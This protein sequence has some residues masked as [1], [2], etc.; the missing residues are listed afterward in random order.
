MLL[1]A[2]PQ[3]LLGFVIGLT[4]SVDSSLKLDKMTS[5]LTLGLIIIYFGLSDVIRHLW[6]AHIILVD[7]AILIAQTFSIKRKGV[8]IGIKYE[9][10]IYSGLSSIVCAIIIV[11]ILTTAK[12]VDIPASLLEKPM[13]SSLVSY[14]SNQEAAN[15]WDQIQVSAQCCGVHNYSDWFGY[16]RH[17]SGS[18]NDV[19]DSCCK[20]LSVGCGQN[21]SNPKNIYSAGCVENL[22]IYIEIQIQRDI[23]KWPSGFVMFIVLVVVCFWKTCVIY[24]CGLFNEPIPSNL[25]L[26]VE[27]GVWKRIWSRVLRRVW[28]RVWTRVLRR[29]W[30][31]VWTRAQPRVWERV[32]TR[33]Q[34]MVLARLFK[35]N[36]ANNRNNDIANTPLVENNVRDD[37]EIDIE[38]EGADTE[39]L[40]NIRDDEENEYRGNQVGSL[41][42]GNSVEIADVH[43]YAC[44]YSDESDPV[45]DSP[46]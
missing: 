4:T 36:D 20:Q 18:P 16:D 9:M 10:F 15:S 34:S 8:I 39:V 33:V 27:S 7:A 44:S 22:K 41:N 17:Q 30:E 42:M 1:M 31:R 32:W 21:I 23:P 3:L 43:R 19:P 40:I 14:S 13:M 6:A 11:Y 37:I 46:C 29:V 28:E 2:I 12:R 35:V 25:A 38:D 45:L 24:T 5:N 26:L